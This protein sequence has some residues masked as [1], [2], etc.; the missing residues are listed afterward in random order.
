MP[1]GVTFMVSLLEETVMNTVN[2]RMCRPPAFY[3]AL[4]LA[5]PEYT[6]LSHCQQRDLQGTT[7]YPLM[8]AESS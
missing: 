3:K 6:Q 2:M 4:E 8:K 7:L 5:E 1:D